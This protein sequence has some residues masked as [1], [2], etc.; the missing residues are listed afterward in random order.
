MKRR[1]EG[2]ARESGIFL[3][4]EINLPVLYV[5]RSFNYDCWSDLPL[6]PATERMTKP[7]T[8]SR[9]E[10]DFTRHN[11][12]WHE[13]SVNPFTEDLARARLAHSPSMETFESSE[14]LS[15]VTNDDNL[16]WHDDVEECLDVDVEESVENASKSGSASPSRPLTASTDKDSGNGSLPNI[17]TACEDGLKPDNAIDQSDSKTSKGKGIE[18]NPDATRKD[19][20]KEPACDSTTEPKKCTCKKRP[21]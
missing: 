10:N 11:L 13:T 9:P 3:K 12:D 1:N 14:V 16:S 6:L 17:P 4:G 8:I 18:T 15:E 20:A 7:R 5:G 19:D 2:E 21:G